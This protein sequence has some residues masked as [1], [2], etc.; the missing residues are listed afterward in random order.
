MK[1]IEKI[2][3]KSVVIKF[4]GDS[5][6]GMQLIGYQFTYNSAYNK[7]KSLNFPEFP[8][9]IRAPRGTVAGVSS[10][11]LQFGDENVLTPGDEYDVLVVMNA[12]ALKVSLKNL[13]ENGVII[14]NENGF[15]LKNLKLAGYE[16]N[17]L[18]DGSLENFQLFSVP[19]EELTIEALKDSPLSKQD[20]ERCKNMFTLGFVCWLFNRTPDNIVEFINSTF[21]KKPEIRDANLKALMAG[22]NYGETSE[23]ILIQYEVP[24]AKLGKGTFRGIM[25]NHAMALGLVTASQK[26]NLPLV[27]CSYPIT[28]ATDILKYLSTYLNFGVKTFQAEDEI[29]AMCAAIGASYGG[30]LAVTGTSGPGMALKTES[31]N[32]AVML[33]LP[34]VLINVQRG[35]PSTGLPTKMEQSDLLFA[36]YGRPGDSPV[37][38]LAPSTPS[39]CFYIA[40]EACKIATSFMTPVI[41]LSDSYLAN[42]AEGWKFPKLE[43]LPEIKHKQL[44]S[45]QKID[46]YY[47]YL[48]DENMVRWW[49]IP[50]NPFTIHRIGGLEKNPETGNVSYFPEDHQRMT[51]IRKKKIQNIAKQIPLQTTENNINEGDV[52]LIGW[53]STYGVIET[54]AR[55]LNEKGYKVGHVHLRYIHPFPSNLQDIIKKFRKVI[56]P[57][58]NTGQLVKLIRDQFLVDAIPFNKVQGIPIKHQELLN[59]VL[60][61][62][63]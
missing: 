28:P 49:A 23:S 52:L 35:G 13:K 29:A 21:S 7:N 24:P 26:A 60:T 20:K 37:P 34:V 25:G 63:K 6:D 16:S 18:E 36:M 3:K 8:S 51:E 48:R 10:F 43:E 61:Q 40:F 59:F 45:S 39:D 1:T 22:Y 9:E 38:V 31:L 46:N 17:P 14:A 30:A 41:V 54:V 57:E 2:Q 55:D 11:Q 15:D 5:G 32:L 50:G 58:L 53:G 27:Y 62:L 47:S 56:I 44:S 4:A 42:G 33:E 12:A 19:I